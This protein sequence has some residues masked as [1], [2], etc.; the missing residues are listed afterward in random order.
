[1]QKQPK[2]IKPEQPKEQKKEQPQQQ[3]FDVYQGLYGKRIVIQEKGG[4]V[5]MG[6]LTGS[7]AGFLHL[8]DAEVH[9]RNHTL[10]L[11]WLCVDRGAVGHF[12]HQVDMP[13]TDAPGESPLHRHWESILKVQK[14]FCEQVA[15]ILKGLTIDEIIK[16]TRGSIG[17]DDLTPEE[18]LTWLNNCLSEA[19][20]SFK[21]RWAKAVADSQKKND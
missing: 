17:S 2:L 9:G 20:K 1:M 15:K 16:S 21:E 5:V 18:R 7:K 10:K 12:H 8:N 11:D 19:E 13:A 3:K 4:C 14:E 6:T